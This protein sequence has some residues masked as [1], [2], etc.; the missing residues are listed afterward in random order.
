MDKNGMRAFDVTVIEP[1][2]HRA[3]V[4]ASYAQFFEVGQTAVDESGKQPHFTLLRPNF[5]RI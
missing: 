1:K 5:R 2:L 4:D 3:A